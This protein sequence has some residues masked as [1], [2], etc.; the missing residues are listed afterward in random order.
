MLGEMKKIKKIIFTGLGTF[1]VLF[2]TIVAPLSP[3]I[4]TIDA[5]PYDDAIDITTKEYKAWRSWLVLEKCIN[6]SGNKGGDK[7]KNAI[8]EHPNSGT[9]PANS[10][11]W[12]NTNSLGGGNGATDGVGRFIDKKDGEIDCNTE[13]DLEIAMANL[14]YKK[15][16]DFM[17]AITSDQRLPD[18]MFKLKYSSEKAIG[19]AVAKHAKEEGLIRSESNLFTLPAESV[20]V[21]WAS[22]AI[23]KVENSAFGNTEG[24]CKGKFGTEADLKKDKTSESSIVRPG[25]IDKDAKE[26]DGW[27]DKATEKGWE[28]LLLPEKKANAAANA[29]DGRMTSGKSTSCTEIAKEATK[30]FRVAA[31][32]NLVKKIKIECEKD[33]NADC[34]S[35]INARLARGYSQKHS[36]LLFVP[37]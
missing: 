14:G 26:I 1:V 27:S 11:G 18:D 12:H 16:G 31:F 5:A 24:T 25:L 23:A 34:E 13:A 9:I 30:D 37:W 32:A 7:V 29:I 33:P 6:F 20:W 36:A 8:F 10:F 17:K 21:Y 2:S 19:A 15:Y 22:L 4:I 28:Y 3:L 35:S